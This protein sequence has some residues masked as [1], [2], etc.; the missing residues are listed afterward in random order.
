MYQ[1]K[2]A[3]HKKM[4]NLTAM[5]GSAREDGYWRAWDMPDLLAI[6]AVK[7]TKTT[8]RKKQAMKSRKNGAKV[9]A[10]KN[11]QK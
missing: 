8:Q 3:V 11:Q 2:L 10:A 1:E 7:K 6:Q 9:K 5:Q 4:N